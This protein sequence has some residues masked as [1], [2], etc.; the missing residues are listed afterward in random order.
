MAARR[1][2]DRP[3]A[4]MPAPVVLPGQVL[5]PGFWGVVDQAEPGRDLADHA[6][7]AEGLA[8]VQFAGDLESRSG[9][10]GGEG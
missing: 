10:A 4:V 9:R 6:D 7:Q 8:G 5:L 1:G 3:P 2:R